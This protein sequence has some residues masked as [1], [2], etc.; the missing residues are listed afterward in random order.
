MENLAQVVGRA[1]PSQ[2]S[3][4]PQERVPEQE[5][6]MTSDLLSDGIQAQSSHHYP[7]APRMTGSEGTSVGDLRTPGPRNIRSSVP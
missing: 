6:G 3:A 4:L 1:L 5:E 7:L 2:D